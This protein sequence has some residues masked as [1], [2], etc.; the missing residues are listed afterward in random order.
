MALCAELA[1]EASTD[2]SKDTLCG[3]N[4]QPAL[5]EQYFAFFNHYRT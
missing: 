3:D 1:L 4:S 2:Q 5:L